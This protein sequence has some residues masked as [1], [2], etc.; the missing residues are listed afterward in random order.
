MRLA[1]V[2]HRFTKGD[3]QGR[4]NYE[5]ARRA[6]EC[7][8]D[9]TLLASE[10]SPDLAA[11]TGARFVPISVAPGR[12]EL[13]RNQIFSQRSAR[14]LRRNRMQFDILHVNGAITSE[15][16]D[17]NS[18]HFVHS[19]WQKTGAAGSHAG[20]LRDLYYRFYTA[21]NANREKAAYRE[22]Q[23]VV[24]VS[25]QVR[26]ELLAIGVRDDHIHVILNGVDLDEFHPG[27]EEH[28]LPGLQLDTP[29]ALFAGDIRTTRKNLDTVLRALADVPALRLIVAGRTEGSPF[30]KMAEKLGVAGRVQFL[31]F[32]RDMA[33]LMRGA[34]F[35]V[36]PS[37]YEA[38]SLVLLEAMASGLPVI[39]ARTAG[40]A[41]VITPDCG[42]VLSDPD[43]AAALANAMQAMAA[44]ARKRQSQGHAARAEAMRHSWTAM[45]DAYLALYQSAFDQKTASLP[46]QKAAL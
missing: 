23:A 37:R 43:D 46:R 24:A 28:A 13:L 22:A 26:Q 18:A 41:E 9:V 38:C 32:R 42:V 5:I 1:L 27:N 30:P 20:G 3:G 16:G 35:F 25:E 6:L 31:G 2:T 10:I 39:T 8:H 7:G 29:I 12:T 14:W 4:V 44:D 21:V 33:E 40:G 45:A 17:V 19:A 11:R 34:D 36:F 15:I